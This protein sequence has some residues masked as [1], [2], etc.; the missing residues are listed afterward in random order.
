MKIENAKIRDVSEEL[1]PKKSSQRRISVFQE[2]NRSEIVYLDIERIEPYKHQSR[3]EFDENEICELAVTIKEHGVRQPLTVLEISGEKYEVISGERRLRAS[4]IAGLKKVPCLIISDETQAEKLALIEN[5][6][7]KDLTLLE[8]GEGFKGLLDREIFSSQ[9]A[10]SKNL[11]ISRSKVV[12]AIAL[13]NLSDNVKDAIIKNKIYERDSLRY[14]LKLKEVDRQIN[15]INNISFSKEPKNF[16]ITQ[17][18][19]NISVLRFSMNASEIKVQKNAISKLSDFEK[20]NLKKEL[21]K[22]LNEL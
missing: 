4:K 19:K 20:E 22:I 11:G 15:F 18:K 6:Q 13:S 21:I 1:M 17:V 3:K 5:V 2:G 16:P 14:I 12:D 7:R 8:L 9:S 10:I